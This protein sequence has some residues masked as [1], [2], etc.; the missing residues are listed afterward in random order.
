MW[1]VV[2]FCLL[3]FVCQICP[4]QFTLNDT[5][6]FA[7]DKNSEYYHKIFIDTN[8]KSEFYAYVSDFKIVDFD[9]DTYKRS[10]D[11]LYTKRLF[12]KKQPISDLPREWVM[13][14]MYKGRIYVYSPADYYFHYKVKITDSLFIDWSGEG[15]EATYIAKSSKINAFTYQFIL[16]SQT[17]PNRT[18]TIK[19]INKEKGIVLFHDR[20]Y[21]SYE[22]RIQQ[23]YLL[24]GDV[25]KMR[26]IPLLVNTCDNE[27]Q[28]ELDFD[29][30]D[31]QKYFNNSPT[32]KHK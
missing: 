1:K 28:G 13:L 32:V 5:L 20:F 22:K 10:L 4:A 8:K 7:R 23:R 25:K 31:Y 6:F 26:N 30:I 12:P 18:L 17:Y 14:E 24:M 9:I 19:Y 3:L 27:K 29:K 21:N 2:L 11:Y 15:P 16:K